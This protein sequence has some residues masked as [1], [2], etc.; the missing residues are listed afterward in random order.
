MN[1]STQLSE[2]KMW[3]QFVQLLF[4]VRL[5]YMIDFSSARTTRFSACRAL[6]PLDELACMWKA[7]NFL[8]DVLIDQREMENVG[9]HY[10]FLS[11]YIWLLTISRHDWYIAI[12]ITSRIGYIKLKAFGTWWRISLAFVV[13]AVLVHDKCIAQLTPWFRTKLHVYLARAQGKELL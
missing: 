8:F 4:P 9:T 1:V 11:E 7:L 2:V 10:Q 3:N 5:R 12:D 13:A 6:V